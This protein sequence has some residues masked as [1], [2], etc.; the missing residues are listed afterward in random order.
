MSRRWYHQTLSSE[1]NTA[2]A[3][4]QIHVQKAV[5]GRLV[6]LLIAACAVPLIAA[7]DEVTDAPSEDG[8][9]AVGATL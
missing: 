6:C 1:L 3:G 9:A 8:H 4:R 7:M 5:L 2:S